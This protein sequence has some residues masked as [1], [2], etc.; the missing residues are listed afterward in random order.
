MT[1]YKSMCH[2][3]ERAWVRARILTEQWDIWP[4]KHQFYNQWDSPRDGSG[5]YFGEDKWAEHK[6]CDLWHGIVFCLKCSFD[7]SMRK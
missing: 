3:K 5:W 6:D 1:W 2:G 7:R 4:H